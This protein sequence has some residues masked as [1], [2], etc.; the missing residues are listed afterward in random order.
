VVQRCGLFIANDSGI[1]HV[2]AAVKTPLIVLFGAA[3]EPARISPRGEQVHVI[4]KVEGLGALS[5]EEVLESV[6]RVRHAAS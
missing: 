3:T 2:A 6:K 5:V 4:K 1:A